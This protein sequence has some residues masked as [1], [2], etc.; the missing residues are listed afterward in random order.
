[1]SSMRD[2]TPYDVHDVAAAVIRE[3]LAQGTP[4]S[5]LQLQKILYLS[6][7]A[8]VRE[9]SREL[10]PEAIVAWQYG[11][12]VKVSYYEYAYRGASSLRKPHR[13]KDG[14]DGTPKPIRNL[15]EAT[16]S[17]I[18]PIIWKWCQRPLWDLV[19]ETH[20]KG[21]PW[22]ITYNPDGRPAGAGYGNA[23]DP[24]CYA[25]F[26][27]PETCSV[28]L[29]MRRGY[30]ANE[31]DTGDATDGMAPVTTAGEPDAGDDPSRMTDIEVTIKVPSHLV[32]VLR[33]RAH[34]REMT[35]Q[36][37]LENLVSAFLRCV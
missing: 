28:E 14:I 23:I 34:A 8:Y 24:W 29:G 7:L 37:Y 33:E 10:F 6:Q 32:G 20:K 15:D 12:V 9:H 26:Y 2:T 25:Q 18:R 35:E 16:M 4:V 21:G 11:P 3:A 19:A 22:D 36:G 30:P 13:T 17:V 27:N 1:M 5:N 31:D